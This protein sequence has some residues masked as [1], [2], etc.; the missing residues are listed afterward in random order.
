MR[1]FQIDTAT[2]DEGP[3]AYASGYGPLPDGMPFLHPTFMK[4]S[5]DFW[6]VNPMKPG[7]YIEPGKRW[8]DFLMNGGSPPGFFV[9]GRVI[10]SLRAIGLPL[11]RVTEMPIAEIKSKGLKDKPAPKYFVVET[12][13]GIEVDF[14]ASNISTDASGKPILT[15]QSFPKSIMLRE[16]SWNGTDLFDYSNF[17]QGPYLNMFCTE[18]VKQLAEKEGWTNVR[19]KP[20]EASLEIRA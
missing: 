20:R 2:C 8:P 9:S 17:S 10:E 13:P 7:L 14:D 18:R 16:S 12:K 6:K 15:P 1:F 11:G 4:Q 5:E 3:F 19:F